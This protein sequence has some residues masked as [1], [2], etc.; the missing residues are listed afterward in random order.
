MAHAYDR[1]QQPKGG[2]ALRLWDW[3]SAAMQ[4]EH[5]TLVVNAP[6][7]RAFEA[8]GTPGW[9]ISWHG[10]DLT[11]NDPNE[12]VKLSVGELIDRINTARANYPVVVYLD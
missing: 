12:T 1:D 3:F 6:V 5:F 7:S 4:T 11:T 9:V 8:A 10:M 2:K